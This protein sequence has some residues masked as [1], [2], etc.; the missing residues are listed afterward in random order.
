MLSMLA[1]STSIV[2]S[3]S[4]AKLS[5]HVPRARA[6]CEFGNGQGLTHAAGTT[7]GASIKTDA[8]PVLK[9]REAALS[10]QAWPSEPR[11]PHGSR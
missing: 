8:Q 11:V 3:S 5:S 1:S 6:I 2:S 9:P 4:S 10:R 7:S